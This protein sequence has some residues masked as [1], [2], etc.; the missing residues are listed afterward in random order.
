MNWPSFSA[1][2]TSAQVLNPLICFGLSQAAAQA[3]DASSMAETAAVTERNQF[4]ISSRFS[5]SG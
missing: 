4:I 2:S 3:E 1:A 5:E